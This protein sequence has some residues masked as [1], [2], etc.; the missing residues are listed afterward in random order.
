[1]TLREQLLAAPNSPAGDYTLAGSGV[2]VFLARWSLADRLKVIAI[3]GDKT[4][5]A[6]AR[7]ADML[8][9]VICDRD[10]KRLFADGD[11]AILDLELGADADVLIDR[12]LDANGLSEKKVP[13]PDSPTN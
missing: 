12:A 13:P 6:T 4:R 2:K 1:M 7:Q 11:A 5:D 10:N 3:S 9:L 8:R